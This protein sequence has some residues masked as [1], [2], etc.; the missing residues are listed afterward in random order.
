MQ[1]AQ[2]A[3]TGEKFL[4]FTQSAHAAVK[5]SR[6]A[7]RARISMQCLEICVIDS[8]RISGLQLVFSGAQLLPDVTSAGAF[9]TREYSEVLLRCT[10]IP[11]VIRMAAIT[12]AARSMKRLF[13]MVGDVAEFRG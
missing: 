13:S 2:K 12:N 3:S 8:A 9:E 10:R 1:N 11:A 7:M 4:I 5:I 6:L